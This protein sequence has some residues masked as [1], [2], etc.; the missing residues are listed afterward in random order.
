MA[1]KLMAIKEDIKQLK[2]I[3]DSLGKEIDNVNF[4]LS[5]NTSDDFDL[6]FTK[7]LISD[8]RKSKAISIRSSAR[9]KPN[10]NKAKNN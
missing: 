9:V 6:E 10:N 1:I 5:S 4:I 7:Y 2:W 8:R 3:D